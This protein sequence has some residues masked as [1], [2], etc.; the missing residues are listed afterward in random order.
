MSSVNDTP[1]RRRHPLT[2][3]E[4]LYSTRRD[5]DPAPRGH[6]YARDQYAVSSALGDSGRDSTATTTTT[7]TGT[8]VGTGGYS[9]RLRS[10]QRYHDDEQQNQAFPTTGVD[11]QEYRSRLAV[12]P[13][14]LQRSADRGSASTVSTA[15]R[16]PCGLLTPFQPTLRQS[17]TGFPLRSSINDDRFRPLDSGVN[18]HHEFQAYHLP[19]PHPGYPTHEHRPSTGAG[20]HRAFPPSAVSSPRSLAPQQASYSP[21]LG[22]PTHLP[23]PHHFTGRPLSARERL[24]SIAGNPSFGSATAL[25]TWDHPRSSWQSTASN[26]GGGISWPRQEVEGSSTAGSVTRRGTGYP[27]SGSYEYE[28]G[29]H[30]RSAGLAPSSVGLSGGNSNER[31]SIGEAY[32]AF[33]STAVATPRE[34]ERRT[35][36]YETRERYPTPELVYYPDAATTTNASTHPTT[37]KRRRLSATPVPPTAAVQDWSY[38]T[39]APVW[40]TGTD[41]H[42]S[43]SR[44]TSPLG[45]VQPFSYAY[46]QAGTGYHAQVEDDQRRFARLLEEEKRELESRR[47]RQLAGPSD[48]APFRNS[49]RRIA[50]ETRGE[51]LDD[52]EFA[53]HIPVKLC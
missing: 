38:P 28:L 22:L 18:N 45:T 15:I 52:R 8:A 44:Q 34:E 40:A 29:S 41:K 43:L 23:A 7:G 42:H 10:Y 21:H 33:P 48:E 19:P 11:S 47:R 17:A 30:V 53:R 46:E 25:S 24:D 20:S 16:W 5:E 9:A 14:G 36:E 13:E 27:D 2:V 51:Y 26:G 49:L 1:G 32:R 39:L 37:T 6:V 4:H 31:W 50:D 12:R 3:D 35:R